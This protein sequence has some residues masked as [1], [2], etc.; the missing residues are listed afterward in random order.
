MVRRMRAAATVMALTLPGAASAN[1]SP[2]PRAPLVQ[3]ADHLPHWTPAQLCAHSVD[4]IQKAYAAG[5]MDGTPWERRLMLT[6]L[7]GDTEGVE[8]ALAENA[9]HLDDAAL[10]A[11]RNAALANAVWAGREATATA[12]LDGGAQINASARVPHLKPSVT[13]AIAKQGWGEKTEQAFQRAGILADQPSQPVGPPL[14]TAVQC[15]DVPMARLLLRRGANAGAAPSDYPARTGYAVITA[16]V[17]KEDAMLHLFLDHGLNPCQ[18]SKVGA[19]TV[20][21]LARRVKLPPALVARLRCLRKAG[22]S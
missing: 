2:P 11:W 6:S 3:M 14:L 19:G 9:Q 5:L 1:E 13:H 4:V 12:L 8:A 18:V 10:Q 20:A 22:G 21:D 15:N 17:L 7:A 16:V